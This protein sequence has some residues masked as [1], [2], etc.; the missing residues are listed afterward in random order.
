MTACGA[1]G[2]SW[3][4]WGPS[5][6][7]G[8]CCASPVLLMIS[9]GREGLRRFPWSM[10]PADDLR[11]WV[12]FPWSADGIRG[13]VGR[14]EDLRR[15]LAASRCLTGPGGK[16]GRAAGS[17]DGGGK[18][19]RV[20]AFGPWWPG[21][22]VPLR[23]SARWA[24]WGPW[25]PGGY[26]REVGR[27]RVGILAWP[28]CLWPDG[29]GGRGAF[30]GRAGAARGRSK[31]RTGCGAGGRGPVPAVTKKPSRSLAT[32]PSRAGATCLWVPKSLALPM[33]VRKSSYPF[34]VG[35]HCSR[36]RA[37]LLQSSYPAAWCCTPYTHT[38][39]ATPP[40]GYMSSYPF[41]WG[42]G[43]KICCNLRVCD[44][45][46]ISLLQFNQATISLHVAN[47]AALTQWKRRS[48]KVPMWLCQGCQV[49]AKLVAK[50]VSS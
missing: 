13:R 37:D 10:V 41:A 38:Y 25:W 11:G 28:G 50:I 45:A 20:P 49:F 24:G 2:P 35:L 30:H 48:C 17:A 32:I 34:A 18:L 5:W 23:R 42:R 7:C 40:L 19:S 29:A 47:Q 14:L 21:C 44:Q 39:Q 15:V 8:A 12:W 4:F 43:F 3:A 31:I 46:T 36:G 6:A 27:G 1:C 33:R 26:G 22:R 16:V 9:R